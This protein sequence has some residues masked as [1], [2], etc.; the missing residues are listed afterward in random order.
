MPK[1]V[2]KSKAK[3]IKRLLKKKNRAVADI[4][5]AV[6]SNW[7]LVVLIDKTCVEHK[8]G[9]IFDVKKKSGYPNGKIW[10]VLTALERKFYGDSFLDQI[11]LDR[12]KLTIVMKKGEHPDKQF[13]RAFQI[14]VGHRH[15]E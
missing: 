4:Q 10:E 11:S 8:P 6:A 1:D 5:I 14:Q 15:K 2:D 7:T 13:E 12:E 9:D 3:R